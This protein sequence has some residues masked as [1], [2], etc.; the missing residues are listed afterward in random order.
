MFGADRFHDQHPVVFG[1]VNI[2]RRSP[3]RRRSHRCSL[4]V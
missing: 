1:L 2:L 3:G 4:D